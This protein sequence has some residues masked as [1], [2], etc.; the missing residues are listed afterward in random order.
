M[1]DS[2]MLG[3]ISERR[4]DSSPARRIKPYMKN[5]KTMQKINA[6]RKSRIQR[7]GFV[8]FWA[9][10]GALSASIRIV[11]FNCAF[12]MRSPCSVVLGL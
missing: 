6:R 8:V 4:P 3:R 12:R 9:G 5:G 1:V 7:F 2:G 10:I 11:L